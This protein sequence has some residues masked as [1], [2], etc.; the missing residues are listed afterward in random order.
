MPILFKSRRLRG[1]AQHPVLPDH[2]EHARVR[3][4]PGI[5]IYLPAKFR[6]RVL[7]PVQFDVQPDQ[8]RY[9]RALVMEEAE[10]IRESIQEA[11][12]DMLRTP[13]QRVVRLS[14]C[15][16]CASSSPG[17]APS[18]AA[19]SRSSSSSS[20]TSRPSSAS[21]ATEPRLPLERTEFVRADSNYSIL[22]R[23]VRATRVDTILHTHLIVGSTEISGRALH[24]INVIGTM[25]LLAAAGAAGSP[26]RKVIVKSSTLMYGAELQ[27]PVLLPRDDAADP[28]AADPGRAVAARCGRIRPRLRDRQPAHDRHEAAVLERARRRHLHHVLQRAASARRS[29]DLR[30]RSPPPV[31]PR[32]RRHRRAAAR[33]A[34]G[35]PR[36]LQ[37]RRR[38]CDAVERGLHDRREAPHRA[39]ARADRVGGG[40]TAHA[41]HRGSP[42][43][44]AQPAALRPRRRQQPVQAHRVPLPVQ[45]R[46]HRQRVRPQSSA[47]AHGRRQ[48]PRRT[49]SSATSRRSSGTPPRSCAATAECRPDGPAGRAVRRASACSRSTT[50]S[51]ATR[52]AKRWSTRSSPRSTSSRP[53]TGIGALVVTGA[54]P[55]F[56]SGADVSALTRLSTEGENPRDVR[57]IYAGFLRVLECPLPTIAAV[58]GPAVGAGFNLALACDVRIAG[59]SARFDAAV[60]PHRDPSRWRPHLAARSGRRSAGRRRDEPLRRAARR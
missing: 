25:N 44:G 39:A 19:G 58:N 49:S 16:A 51:A 56:C 18:G 2:R 53:T 9:P 6:L 42:A 5:G 47:R 17:S 46:G 21:T 43:R 27:G 26:V 1:A 4:R 20:T 3:A 29:R 50:R 11:L 32:G 52:S 48:A 13:P 54:P 12:Y 31:H 40:A 24:E 38:R 34:Q 57:D 10:K 35:R 45:H 55:A 33:D 30:L 59:T 15:R 22:D 37:R 28:P 7:P 60:P 14:R 23:I 41:A 8:E 36:D